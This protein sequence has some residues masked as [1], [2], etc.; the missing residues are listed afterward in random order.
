VR[1]EL[2]QFSTPGQRKPLVADALC[3]M[4]RW[5]RKT[6]K[7]WYTYVEN[8]KPT[9]DTEVLELIRTLSCE[10]A[11]PQRQFT[12]HEI[13]ERTLYGLINEAA[14]VL[15]EG[16][17]RRASDIDVIYVNGYGFPG[18]RGG[19]LF[20]ADSVGLRHVVERISSF[21]DEFGERW[22]VSPLLLKL[23]EAGKTFR[24]FDEER[25]AYG[26]QA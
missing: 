17:A 11:I 7:G 8:G 12:D 1:R 6:G 22:K 10:A 23:A 20:Y 15:G 24:S 4:G 18:W 16:F 13:V 19:P 21:K 14:R 26:E 25:G 9:P 3:E 5:G 2:H